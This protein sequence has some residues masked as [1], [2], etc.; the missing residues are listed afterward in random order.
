MITVEV[1]DDKL[2]ATL[3]R[4]KEKLGPGVFKVIARACMRIEAEAK[5]R[6]PVGVSG[7]LRASIGHKVDQLPDGVEGRVGTRKLVYALFVHGWLEG[8]RWVGPRRH[9]VPF[10]VAPGLKRWLY[11][12]AHWDPERLE[13]MKGIMVGGK[14]P[15]PFL[16]PLLAKYK[17]EILADL[18]Q[19]LKEV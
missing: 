18:R 19:A 9:F 16:I 10:S 17:P 4:L 5:R 12:K 7:N 8:G 3:G 2:I 13:R 11:L 1:H 14:P 15:T 6:T